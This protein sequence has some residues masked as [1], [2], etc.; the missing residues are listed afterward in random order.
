ML[1]LGLSE[2]Q[3]PPAW[4]RFSL[5][6]KT[7][8]VTEAAEAA[9]TAA[10]PCSSPAKETWSLVYLGTLP[11]DR[12]LSRVLKHEPNGQRVPSHQ[13]SAL[14]NHQGR[15]WFCC[16]SLILYRCLYASVL[17]VGTGSSGTAGRNA[18]LVWVSVEG[19]ISAKCLAL[20]AHVCR[21]ET[22][23]SIDAS[24]ILITGFL[25]FAWESICGMFQE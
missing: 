2:L 7:A 9:A 10:A 19:L 4:Q 1:Y 25:F 23:V 16:C 17:L 15:I 12:A 3:I 6:S 18:Q 8:A 11:V 24:F 21:L 22:V 20:F 5:Q 14:Q 13:V